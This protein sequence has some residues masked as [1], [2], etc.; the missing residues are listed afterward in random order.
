M[1][2]ALLLL[3]ALSGAAGFAMRGTVPPL[4]GR[5]LLVLGMGGTLLGLAAMTLTLLGWMPLR[6]WTASQVSV[7]LLAVGLLTLPFALTSGQKPR[8][9]RPR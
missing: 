3:M 4:I 7:T 1:E 8:T 9:P 6:I 2:L 5:I